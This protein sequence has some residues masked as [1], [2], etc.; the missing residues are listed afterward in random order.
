MT[1]QNGTAAAVKPD[2]GN[3]EE[4]A[5]NQTP[6][7]GTTPTQ[8]EAPKDEKQ[9]KQTPKPEKPTTD[10]PPLEDRILRVN[11]LFSLVEKLE[12]LQD[13]K[14]KLDSF[15]LSSEGSRDVLRIQ[16]G[17]GN[18]FQT[19]NSAA[20]ADVIETLKKSLAQKIKEVE[21]QIAF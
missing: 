2:N 3:P 14:R 8:P 5:V 1:K 16:D 19:S 11:Q 18:E 17:R 10:L 4:K 9:V 7:T 6:N 15:K 13:T 12:A 20:I 21:N